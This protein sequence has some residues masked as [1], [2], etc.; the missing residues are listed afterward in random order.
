MT[1]LHDKRALVLGGGTGIGRSVATLFSRQGAQV[2][3]LEV[4]P[5]KC[6]DLRAD[7]CNFEVVQGDASGAAANSQAV[8]RCEER[9]GGIDILVN[10]VGIFD[11]YRGLGDLTSEQL[12]G[13][14]E[15]IFAV[16]VRSS[17][18][19]THAALP[20]LR[21]SRGS[22]ILTESTSGYYPG[23]GGVLYVSSKFAVRGIRISLAHDLA[24]KVRVNSVAP[25]GTVGSQL[26]GLRALDEDGRQ[27]G[28]P[29]R[30]ASIAARTPLQVALNGDDHAWSYLFLAS[31][32]SRGM[33]GEVLH[34][35]GGWGIRG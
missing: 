23:R 4:S 15:E 26:S 8:A 21:R 9:F 25:G 32:H 24:P 13:A 5:E 12:D 3:V 6:E 2:A 22:V 11:F 33:T 17:L 34:S 19:A 14:F 31:S 1:A 7:E 30:A 28:G 35:D 16:N 10:C 20:S 29:D 27:L 18:H